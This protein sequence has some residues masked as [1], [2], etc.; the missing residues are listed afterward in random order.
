MHSCAHLKSKMSRYFLTFAFLEFGASAV[1]AQT[2]GARKLC[3]TLVYCILM[4][5]NAAL[6]AGHPL[7]QNLQKGDA[8]L[9]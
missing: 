9:R 6:F 4:P 1:C 2:M 8:V 7:F 5:D 3:L